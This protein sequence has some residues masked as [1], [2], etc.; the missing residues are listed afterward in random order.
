M[1]AIIISFGDV[2]LARFPFT[3]LTSD[4]RR[5]VLVV[6]VGND[7]EDVTVCAITSRP[8]DGEF[9]VAVTASE[10]NGL[11]VT[12]RVQFDKIATLER[13][14]ISGK[15]GSMTATFMNTHSSLFFSQFGF[16]DE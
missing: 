2:L 3:D 13:S 9:D 8:H 14:V 4:K 7:G 11:K 12:S 15:L 6:S 10:D 5:P 16:T 1:N